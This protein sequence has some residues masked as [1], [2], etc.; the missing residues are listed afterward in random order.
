MVGKTKRKNSSFISRQINVLV[1][2]FC[3]CLRQRMKD[4]ECSPIQSAFF[5]QPA[6]INFH[7]TSKLFGETDMKDCVKNVHNRGEE[8]RCHKAEW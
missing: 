6:K 2:C 7:P 1:P 3:L 5:S 4:E 8:I